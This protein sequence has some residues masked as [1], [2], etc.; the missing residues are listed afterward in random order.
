MTA[1][2]HLDAAAADSR[3]LFPARPHPAVS[4]QYVH[5]DTHNFISAMEQEGFRVFDI[6]RNTS[7]SRD[8]LY[9]R[10]MVRFEHVDRL[11][12]GAEVRPQILFMNSHDRSCRATVAAGLIRWA[13]FNG[14]V[15]GDGPL[16]RLGARHT[17]DMARDL[18][19]RAA[20]LARNTAPLFA[21]ID[22]WSRKELSPA[23]AHSLA[24]RA[25]ALRWPEQPAGRFDLAQILAA[26]R[27]EDEG[28]S[29]WR[30]FNRIQESLTR[31]GLEG[32]SIRGTSIRTR[33]LN[34]INTDMRFNS[35]FWSVA[36][37]LVE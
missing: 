25:V 34:E 24:E 17:G 15:V 35:Q 21:Q 4:A 10:H 11:Y 36:A 18:I 19:A 32:R 2:I 3:Q 7:R 1:V 37:E 31:G 13:C 33:P 20:D 28:M 9:L 26:R 6:R 12:D 23:Q 5:I 8:P 29:L 22:R 14:M 16:Q 30:V 27:P